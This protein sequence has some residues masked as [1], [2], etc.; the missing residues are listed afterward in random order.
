MNKARDN[1]IEV[2]LNAKSLLA[3]PDNDFSWSSWDNVNDAIIEVDEIIAKLQSGQSPDV[4]IMKIIFAP[5]GPMQEVGLSSG[6]AEPF[7]KL[8]EHFDDALEE[9]LRNN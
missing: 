5:T 2:F 4:L 3:L 9:F 1:L 7:L 6:W 8:A